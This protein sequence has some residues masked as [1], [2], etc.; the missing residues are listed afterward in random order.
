MAY[1]LASSQFLLA[2]STAFVTILKHPIHF[3]RPRGTAAGTG[4][5][6]K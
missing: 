2:K 3:E 6:A 4:S 5:Q 1:L